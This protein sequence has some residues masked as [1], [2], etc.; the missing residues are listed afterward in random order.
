MVTMF[1]VT[2]NNA[3]FVIE[4]LGGTAEV[5]RLCRVSSQA[6][7]KWKR[8]G[9]PEARLMYLQAIRPDVFAAH[10]DTA[11]TKNPEAA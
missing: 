3:P 8:E 1:A 4:L 7:S 9:I 2:H 5:S 11:P 10:D 6:V